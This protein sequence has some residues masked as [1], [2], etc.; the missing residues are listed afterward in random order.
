MQTTSLRSTCTF[1]VI[2]ALYSL[3]AASPATQATEKAQALIQDE[4]LS[5]YH[6]WLKYL[7]FDVEEVSKRPNVSEKAAAEKLARLEDWVA[8]ISADPNVIASLKGQ[9]EWAYESEADSSGQPFI[10][11]IPEDYSSDEATPLSVFLHGAN[12]DHQDHHQEYSNLRGKFFVS[13]LGRSRTGAYV[14]L[15]EADV[16]DVIDYVQANWNIDPDRIHLSGLSMGAGGV[17]QLASRYP[18]RFASASPICGTIHLKPYANLLTMPIYA[19]FS[20]D[21]PQ[22]PYGPIQDTFAKLSKMGGKAVLDTTV[23]LG[24]AAWTYEEGNRRNKLWTQKQIRPDS[25]DVRKIDYTAFDGQAVRGW[26]A[27]IEKWGSSPQAARFV[28]NTDRQ[29]QLYA[30]LENIDTLE[31]LLDEAPFDPNKSLQVSINAK[32]PLIYDAPLPDSLYLINGDNGWAISDSIVRPEIRRRTPGGPNLLYNGDP[33]LIVYGTQGNEQENQAMLDAARIASQRK[34]AT[35]KARG[36]GKVK[37]GVRGNELLYE[38]LRIVADVDLSQADHQR[39]H[40]VLIGTA[41]QNKVVSELSSRLPVS[42]DADRIRFS[43]GVMYPSSG[44]GLGLVHYNPE[45][46]ENLIFW[47]ASNNP[48]LYRLDSPI[49][50]R[51]AHQSGI[52][53]YPAPPIDCLISKVDSPTMVAARSFDSDWRWNPRPSDD[54]RTSTKASDGPSYR[55]EFLTALRRAAGSDFAYTFGFGKGIPFVPGETYISDVVANH[56]YEKV[57][58]VRVRG[59]VLERMSGNLPDEI[60]DFVPAPNLAEI[61]PQRVY[62]IAM[63]QIAIWVLVRASKTTAP[64]F[65]LTDVDVASV[66]DEMLREG[67]SR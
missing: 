41:T 62:T 6:G 31:L 66:V 63:P 25:K 17:Y 16:L 53:F 19:T 50:A 28:L 24:H 2:V 55:K 39:N 36:P 9:Q 49:P 61:D 30:K 3:S 56:E 29:N 34:S 58:I 32:P 54:G 4:E 64:D 23:G 8:R 7:I 14:G 43:D 40:L 60:G 45:A 27:R 20:I 59:D 1:L 67:S 37:D 21:D 15:A 65:Y 26:W 13:V 11:N 22:S 48:K 12:G 51:M 33:L 35:W 18:H 44:Y 46:P 5:V 10:I 42:I 47:V 57:G 38:N 52:V